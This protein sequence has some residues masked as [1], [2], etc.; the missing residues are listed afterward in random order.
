[1]G[2]DGGGIYCEVP[3]SMWSSCTA[4]LAAVTV[5]KA[6]DVAMFVVKIAVYT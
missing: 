6:A 1:M 2:R 3:Q 4:G 5:L